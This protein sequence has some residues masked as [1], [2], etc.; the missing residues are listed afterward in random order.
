MYSFKCGDVR[1]IKLKCVSK[2]PSK[3]NKFEEYE[4]CLNG[5]K[6][7]RECDN[8]LLRSPNLEMY[9]QKV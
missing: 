4:N 6:Y 2:S 5:E 3:Y 1:K 9:L 8:Y 7:Q